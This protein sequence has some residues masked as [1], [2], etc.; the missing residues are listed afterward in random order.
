MILAFFPSPV[1]VFPCIDARVSSPDDLPNAKDEP[2]LLPQRPKKP[3]GH[4]KTETLR[5]GVR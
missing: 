5:A 3:R 4:R 1:H 2:L